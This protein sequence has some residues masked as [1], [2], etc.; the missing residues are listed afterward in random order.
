MTEVST[1]KRIDQ[2]QPSKTPNISQMKEN[3]GRISNGYV[4]PLDKTWN[5]ETMPSYGGGSSG[6]VPTS[7]GIAYGTQYTSSPML[8]PPSLPLASYAKNVY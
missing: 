6:F 8:M 5:R 3:I 1:G 7:S 2:V 4:D